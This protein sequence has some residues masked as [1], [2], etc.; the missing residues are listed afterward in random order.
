[1]GWFGFY[2]PDPYRHI[3]MDPDPAKL[4][5]SGRIPIRNTNLNITPQ[6]VRTMVVHNAQP[7]H[8]PA[9]NLQPSIYTYLVFILS[10]TRGRYKV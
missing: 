3:M 8:C 9:Y 2:E 6:N 4:N 5:G 10:V 7:V 1:M